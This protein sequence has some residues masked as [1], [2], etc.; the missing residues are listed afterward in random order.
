MNDEYDGDGT[1]GRARS[2]YE[3]VQRANRE[4]GVRRGVAYREKVKWIPPAESKARSTG[5]KGS[6]PD[7][8]IVPP[9]AWLHTSPIAMEVRV[10]P[11]S[12]VEVPVRREGGKHDN[13]RGVEIA[14]LLC[15]LSRSFNVVNRVS[16]GGG[17]VPASLCEANGKRPFPP[18]DQVNTHIMNNYC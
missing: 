14:R 6:L 3:P 15:H 9:G 10:S 5:G 11:T 7:D 2:V 8:C 17:Y 12:N 16:K 18:G 1:R 4:G 13:V